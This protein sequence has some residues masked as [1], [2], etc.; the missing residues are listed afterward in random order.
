MSDPDG[1]E[2]GVDGRAADLTWPE[3][4]ARLRSGTPLILPVG[5]FEQHGP[6]LPLCTDTLIVEAL[7]H[8][9]ARRVGALVLPT[10]PFGAPARPHTGGGD[11]F[12]VPDLPLATLIGAV[13][14]LATGAI[15]AGC[16]WLVVL[17]WHLEN[18]AVLWDALRL[19]ASGG[20]ATIQLFAEP[21]DYL[22][23]E[24][25]DELF[26]DVAHWW[27]SDHAGRLETAM[28]RHLAPN[29][30]GE[31]PAPVAFVPRQGYD[32]LPTPSDAVPTTGAVV[33]A[34][35]VTADLGERS[36][37]AI[38]DVIAEAISTE[39]GRH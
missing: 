33:D 1:S 30:V 20:R 25:E 37:N 23:R 9:V 7:A 18:S 15:N 8:R 32:V 35:D 16:Q 38:V 26:H 14:A 24:L 28:M 4:S 27:Y 34:R 36:T 29:L 3:L 13:E 21:W 12:P 39:R 11:L 2:P 19:P 6:H 22:T 5:S 31:P 10:L 17:S